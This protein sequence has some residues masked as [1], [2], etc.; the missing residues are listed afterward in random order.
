M[1][2]VPVLNWTAKQ[3]RIL[4][5]YIH[6]PLPSYNQIHKQFHGN[7]ITLSHKSM[8]TWGLTECKPKIADSTN[9]YITCSGKIA[10]N[11]SVRV[12]ACVRKSNQYRHMPINCVERSLSKMNSKAQLVIWYPLYFMKIDLNS[13][14]LYNITN[15]GIGPKKCLAQLEMLVVSLFSS[16]SPGHP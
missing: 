15:F 5:R 8:N 16:D 9:I 7:R 14:I 13:P 3:K 1:D 6:T 11:I 12:P 10:K 2:T 4:W